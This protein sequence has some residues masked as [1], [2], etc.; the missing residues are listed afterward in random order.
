MQP[1]APGPQNQQAPMSGPQSPHAPMPGIPNPQQQQ[2]QPSGVQS[3]RPQHPQMPPAFAT[4]P[5]P[6]LN[7][8]YQPPAQPGGQQPQPMAQA[9]GQQGLPPFP[10]ADQMRMSQGP[11]H[12]VPAPGLVPPGA[13]PQ[14]QQAQQSTPVP[15]SQQQTPRP[16]PTP[17]PNNP[18]LMQ[19]V[20]PSVHSQHPSQHDTPARPVGAPGQSG[21]PPQMQLPMHGGPPGVQQQQQGPSG[22]MP[23]PM[24][25]GHPSGLAQH[26][27]Q[28][29]MPQMMSPMA[30]QSVHAGSPIT[31]A[32]PP[33]VHQSIHG[34]LPF[35]PP[36]QAVPPAGSHAPSVHSIQA[37][38]SSAQQAQPM[39]MRGADLSHDHIEE[40]NQRFSD[41]R[42][43]EVMDLTKEHQVFWNDPDKDELEAA[44]ED[45][46]KMYDEHQMDMFRRERDQ[47][48]AAVLG[49]LQQGGGGSGRGAGGAAPK[50][51]RGSSAGS[52]ESRKDSEGNEPP[53]NDPP[54][55][56]HI[57]FAGEQ[58]AARDVNLERSR[59][60]SRSPS[61]PRRHRRRDAE[62]ERWS[63][64]RRGGAERWRH[65][66]MYYSS[67]AY[68]GGILDSARPRPRRGTSEP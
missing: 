24:G 59:S 27:L 35:A 68:K 2:Q 41:M 67:G 39:H 31:A 33:S 65:A 64:R 10:L 28:Q 8:M 4:A 44:L 15:P 56:P 16:P 22:N 19:G 50:A 9:Q 47:I 62:W 60:P 40:L 3:P 30:Q 37:A 23:M 54:A 20:P 5:T 57:S 18:Q 7:N 42:V 21:P 11:Q 34:G 12:M 1:G 55:P 58:P 25:A 53:V 61:R 38:G 36:A 17:M 45:S 14:A 49:N 48:H 51:K 29:G 13:I 32:A 46:L 6:Q 63:S 52:T 26:P 43:Q 66:G